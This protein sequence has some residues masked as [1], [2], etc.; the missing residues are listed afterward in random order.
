MN[1]NDKDALAAAML[2]KAY[3]NSINNPDFDNVC[4]GCIF[5][6]SVGSFDCL[7]GGAHLP[8]TWNLDKAVKE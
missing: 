7:L 2:I 3:C 4:D 8:D 5:D 1:Q 6:N